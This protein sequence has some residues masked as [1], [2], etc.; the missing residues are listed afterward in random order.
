[1]RR[2]KQEMFDHVAKQLLTQGKKAAVKDINGRENYRY[3]TSDGCKCSAGHVIPDELYREAFEGWSVDDLVD[4]HLRGSQELYNCLTDEER[5]QLR[6]CFVPTDLSVLDGP[7]NPLRF[8]IRL[9][10][11]HDHLDPSDWRKEL[12][13]FAKGFGISDAVLAQL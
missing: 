9:Q 12:S 11:I 13:E 5:E 10:N 6:E 3:R 8:I 1:M 2:T 7:K 4:P